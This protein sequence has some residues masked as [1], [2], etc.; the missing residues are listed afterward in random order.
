MLACYS[1]STK[2]DRRLRHDALIYYFFCTQDSSVGKPKGEAVSTRMKNIQPTVK[3]DTENKSVDDIVLK[4]QS[5]ITTDP[6]N[7]VKTSGQVNIVSKQSEADEKQPQSAICHAE[8]ENKVMDDQDTQKDNAERNQANENQTKAN[9]AEGNQTEG[10]QA[11][12]NQT[13]GEQAEKNQDS[14]ADGQVDH[15]NSGDEN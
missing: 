4:T 7:S 14:Q 13:E 1:A 15:T 9:Q 8:D 3:R 11:E 12:K 6:V 5:D 2:N 10:N